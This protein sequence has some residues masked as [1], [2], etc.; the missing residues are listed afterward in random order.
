MR[1]EKTIRLRQCQYPHAPDCPLPRAK[2]VSMGTSRKAGVADDGALRLHCGAWERPSRAR[3]ADQRGDGH[4]TNPVPTDRPR[5][6]R[7]SQ[8]SAREQIWQE[9]ANSIARAQK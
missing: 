1:L 7:V 4:K 3:K 8:T 9:K 6:S 2:A 5:P